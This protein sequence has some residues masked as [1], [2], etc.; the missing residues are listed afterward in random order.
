MAMLDLQAPVDPDRR[1]AAGFVLGMHFSELRELA[2]GPLRPYEICEK[3]SFPDSRLERTC[4][5]ADEAVRLDFNDE[6]RLG[7][8]WVFEGYEGTYRGVAVGDSLARVS[9]QEALCYDPGDGYYRVDAD[10]EI[11]PGLAIC[12]HEADV[13]AHDSVPIDGFCIHDWGFFRMAS[14]VGGAGAQRE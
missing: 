11:L 9:A 2:P 13:S 8:I 12:A 5:L 14:D 3:V 4:H 10:N 7:A 6:G 1:A